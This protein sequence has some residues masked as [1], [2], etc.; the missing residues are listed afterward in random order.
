MLVIISDLHLTDGSTCETVNAGAFRQFLR[1]LAGQAE[2][3]CWRLKPGLQEGVF[4]PLE[5][6]DVLLLGDIL[7]VMRSEHWLE[8]QRYALGIAPIA[9]CRMWH[10][11]YP[12]YPHA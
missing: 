10:G 5:R 2:S 3:A 1:T 4:E 11:D 12:P 8:P 7:D 6:I 9:Y